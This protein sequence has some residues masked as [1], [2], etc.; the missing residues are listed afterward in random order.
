MIENRVK[1]RLLEG[2]TVLG[3]FVRS[4]DATFAEYVASCGWDFLVFD[5]EHG[6]VGRGDVANLARA[7][8]RRSV[9]P[10][11]RV[12][13]GDTALVLRCLDGG[14]AGL[15]FP[16]ISDADQARRAVS[17]TR[18]GPLGRRGLAGNRATDWSVT[19]EATARANRSTLVVVQI[20]TKEGVDNIEDVCSVEDVDVIFVGPTDLSQSLGVPGEY[21]HPLVVEAMETVAAAARTSGKVF[22]LFAG[23]PEAALRGME[24]GARYIA[25]GVEAVVG[26]AMVSFIQAMSGDR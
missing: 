26:P 13:S 8:E 24:M 23:T 25:T 17:A 15:H 5:E 7:C 3:C 11:V 2:E 19:T 4:P 20:E 1:E 10:I 22:G 6:S 9:T 14:A 21:A 18:Y 12:S 16:W